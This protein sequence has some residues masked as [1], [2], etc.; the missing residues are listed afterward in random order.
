MSNLYQRM[1]ETFA[2]NMGDTLRVSHQFKLAIVH[3]AQLESDAKA[4]RIAMDYLLRS[5]T[6]LV[7]S[8]ADRF[9]DD[10]RATFQTEDE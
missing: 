9:Y 5:P 3:I 10:E 6:G 1:T 4:M 8:E 2:E 7:P